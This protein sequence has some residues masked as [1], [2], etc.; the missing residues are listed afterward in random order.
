[1]HEIV[2]LLNFVQT[3]TSVLP[4]IVRV[5]VCVWTGKMTTHVTVQ[6]DTRARHVKQ[7]MYMT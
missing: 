2:I 3:L 6:W 5:E 7:V 4:Y 1:V